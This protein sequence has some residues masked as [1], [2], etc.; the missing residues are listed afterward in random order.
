[1]ITY[2]NNDRKTESYKRVSL[3]QFVEDVRQERYAD[4][5]R[6]I[7]NIIG[8]GGVITST[9]DNNTVSVSLRGIPSVC[10]ASEI[11]NKKGEKVIDHYNHLI[12]LEI[13]NLVD[14]Q[15]ASH[16]NSFSWSY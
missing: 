8:M 15:T 1:M 14:K 12:L 4:N 13:K 16:L 2:I 5:L 6:K 3:E 10:F 9:K 11:K 7:R